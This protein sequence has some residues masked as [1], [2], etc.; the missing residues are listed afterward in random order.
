[1]EKGTKKN[2]TEVS[3]GQ[4]LSI[5]EN[6]INAILFGIPDGTLLDANPAAVEMF[7]YSIEELRKLGRGAIF[8]TTDP[9]MIAALKTRTETGKAKGEI[10]GIRKNGE[11]FPCEFSSAI[12]KTETGESRTSTVLNDISERKKAEEE[13]TLLMDNTEESFVLV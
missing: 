3:H 13:I 1:M 9:K 12:F 10:I 2:E 4:F 5:F 8:D 6:S 11:R 7:G